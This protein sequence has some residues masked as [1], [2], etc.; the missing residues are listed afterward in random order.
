MIATPLPDSA[1]MVGSALKAFVGSVVA[2]LHRTVLI[3]EEAEP[4]GRR[5]HRD[6][7]TEINGS[8]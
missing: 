8:E 5:S 4:P 2:E 6:G 3:Q 7:N 1:F